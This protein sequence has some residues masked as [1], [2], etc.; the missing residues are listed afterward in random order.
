MVVHKY[1][2]AQKWSLIDMKLFMTRR[3]L[4][5]QNFISRLVAGKKKIHSWSHAVRDG[6]IV[7]RLLTAGLAVWQFLG[8]CGLKGLKILILNFQSSVGH[9]GIFLCIAFLPTNNINSAQNAVWWG[10]NLHTG[11][12]MF[13]N[14]TNVII[15]WSKTHFFEQ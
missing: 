5:D 3:G 13:K 4:V 7:D 11:C 9:P 14:M 2:S 10:C 1:L 12:F 8:F 15:K 6:Q